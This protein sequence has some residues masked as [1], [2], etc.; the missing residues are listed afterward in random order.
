MA[1]SRERILKHPQ[2]IFIYAVESLLL[3]KLMQDTELIH[4]KTSM[5]NYTEVKL[6]K[7]NLTYK[8]TVATS[9]CKF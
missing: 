6:I 2:N 4:Y 3:L 8:Y 7:M 1:L 5:V 9:P